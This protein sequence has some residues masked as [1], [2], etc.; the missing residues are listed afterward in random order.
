MN[1]TL[2]RSPRYWT[3]LRNNTQ[4]LGGSK[5]LVEQKMFEKRMI[6]LKEFKSIRDQMKINDTHL[7]SGNF[8]GHHFNRLLLRVSLSLT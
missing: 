4:Y 8:P 3:R 6:I 2:L 5:S 7:G 1:A